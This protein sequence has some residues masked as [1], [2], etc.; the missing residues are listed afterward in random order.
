MKK[1]DLCPFVYGEGNYKKIKELG[2]GGYGCVY[3]A[4]EKKTKK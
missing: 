1:E 3:L 4:E 2:R